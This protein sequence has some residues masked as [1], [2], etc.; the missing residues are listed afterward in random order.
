MKKLMLILVAFVALSAQAQ[1]GPEKYKRVFFKG[2]TFKFGDLDVTIEDALAVEDFTKFKMRVKNNSA[3]I[4]IVKPGNFSLKTNSTE[5]KV[6]EKDMI[7]MPFDDASKV[8]DVK[9]TVFRTAS[10]QVNLTGF[11]TVQ[12][13][14]FTDAPPFKLPVSQNVFE[15]GDF[16]VTHMKNEKKTDFVGVRLLVTYTGNDVAIIQPAEAAL[17]FP[18]G[19]EFA[20]MKNKPKPM[21]LERGKS[22][23]IKLEWAD[24]PVS[25]GDAQ[26]ANLE[27]L[28]RKTFSTG[29]L[30]EIP[31]QTITLEWD[32]GM[33]DAKK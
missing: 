2:A 3:N 24:I 16:K 28:W 29:K 13:S 32:P 33:T 26:F 21:I 5:Y 9:G 22:D 8:V 30:V 19:A 11:Y 7:I 12:I 15:A 20:N 18:N 14:G 17:K 23:D 10:Y 31:G 6:L 4:V 25:N 27:I 1:K